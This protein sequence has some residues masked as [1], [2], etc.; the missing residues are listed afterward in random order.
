M[1]GATTLQINP[2]S[3]TV[4]SRRAL[5][6]DRDGVINVDT[7]YLHRIEECEFIPGVFDLARR[8]H[9][10]DYAIIVV[11]NQAGIARGLYSEQIFET[12]MQWMRAEFDAQGAPLTDVYHCPH[13]PEVGGALL[14]MRCACRKPAPGMLLRA[15]QEWNIDLAASM[16]VGDSV[17]DIEA[18]QAAGVQRRVLFGAASTSPAHA[19]LDCL[20]ATTVGEI[21]VLC[22]PVTE[23]AVS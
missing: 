23:R 7:G 2:A 10:L 3:S 11:T 13:H 17:T 16:L 9:A 20:R 18:A 6:L 22:E 15:A 12:F 4:G 21:E 8:A 5:F 19:H 1:T 14:R